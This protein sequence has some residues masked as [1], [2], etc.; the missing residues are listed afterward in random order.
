MSDRSIFKRWKTVHLV[1]LYTFFAI[2]VHVALVPKNKIK[3][4]WSTDIIIKTVFAPR[5]MTRSCFLF[6]L[7]FFHL[8]DNEKLVPQDSRTS[9]RSIRF[10]H[11]STISSSYLFLVTI[12]AK[13][14]LQ[15]D[16]WEH[17]QAAAKIFAST[18]PFAPAAVAPIIMR[19]YMRHK[20]VKW[21]IKLYQL[22]E[23]QSGYVTGIE[24][25]AQM[26]YV[27]NTSFSVCQCL[28]S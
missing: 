8:N 15:T 21:E 26:P 1:E 11:S 16:L 27:C 17:I 12:L 5:L 25:M 6:I 22:C 20:A 19:V 4:Y 18:T 9:I 3:D 23:S 10:A 24:I 14:L 7:S 28:I 2:L 13:P